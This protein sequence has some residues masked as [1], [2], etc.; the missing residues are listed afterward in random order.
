MKL[1]I[2]RFID[3]M[4]ENKKRTAIIG[5]AAFV[6]LALGVISVTFA[7]NN[8]E[9]ILKDYLKDMGKEFYENLYYDQVEQ[10]N[11]TKKKEFL[12][13]FSEIGIK[14]SLDSL[15]RYNAD[16]NKEKLDAFVNKKTNEHC[17]T[18]N[19]KVII[20]P[21][22]PYGKSDYRMDVN[23]VCGFEK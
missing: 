16:K 14:I 8:Q 1:K 2:S 11:E 17:D 18:E 15:S 4:K 20:Y 12:A 21:Q 5:V 9:A 10:K 22:E 7:F 13:K 3:K 6:I 19:T 23:L